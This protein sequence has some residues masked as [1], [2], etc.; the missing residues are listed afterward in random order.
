M[1]VT[2]PIKPTQSV[3][4]NC[5]NCIYFDFE[6]RECSLGYDDSDCD[7]RIPIERKKGED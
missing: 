5:R 4:A 1:Y 2:I 3:S 7:C 6:F